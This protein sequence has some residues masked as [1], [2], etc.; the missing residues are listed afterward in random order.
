V[1]TDNDIAR[2]WSE[3]LTRPE[4]VART[5]A[6]LAHVRF[7]VG[8]ARQ[9]ECEQIAR[10]KRI[11]ADGARSELGALARANHL[12]YAT[13]YARAKAGKHG[14]ELTEPTRKWDL[15]VRGRDGGPIHALPKT[16]PILD[17]E[18]IAHI[19]LAKFQ[20]WSVEKICATFNV[21]PRQVQVIRARAPVALKELRW[22]V[23]GE[24]LTVEE[25]AMRAPGVS[26][27]AIDGR[28][29]RGWRGLQLL[30]PLQR[31]KKEEE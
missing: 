22:N 19:A 29:R 3:G 4:I 10:H 26:V 12:Q 18:T 21:H 23:A 20:G 8:K 24:L 17:E 27:A 14:K 9:I 7:V 25:I 31:V 2:L 5:D 16:A 6:S 30:Q 1:N 11:H 13:V 28:I 15:K